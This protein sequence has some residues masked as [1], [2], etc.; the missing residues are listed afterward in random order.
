MLDRR[1]WRAELAP[2]WPQGFWDDWLREPPQRRGRAFLRPEVS[3]TYT[4]G[5]Q[6]V[7]Q[8][9]FFGRYLATVRLNEERVDWA[10]QDL[11]Y[12][13]KQTYDAGL[14]A[15]VAAG[16]AWLRRT[17]LPAPASRHS[18]GSSRDGRR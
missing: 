5:E 18:R 3:R 14:A 16:R 15:A 9:Q 8:A 11:S 2:K 10:A 7:S 13:A 12:L 4:F 6:G 17:R 1:R